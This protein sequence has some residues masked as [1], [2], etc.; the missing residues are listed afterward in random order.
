M[1]KRFLKILFIVNRSLLKSILLFSQILY[2]LSFNIGNK[3]SQEQSSSNNAYIIISAQELNEINYRDKPT[4]LRSMQLH[5]FD[6]FDRS[7]DSF[8]KFDL[9]FLLYQIREDVPNI[10]FFNF[11]QNQSFRPP[12]YL[13]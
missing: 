10:F 1:P 4:R 5:Q 8:S 12:P 9:N 2:V 6:N 7:I 11:S 13:V 3:S